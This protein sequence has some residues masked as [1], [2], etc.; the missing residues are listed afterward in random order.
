MKTIFLAG[1]ALTVVML[2]PPADA[3]VRYR[4][5]PPEY[6]GRAYPTAP[7]YRNSTDPDPFIR[8]QILRDIPERYH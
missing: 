6:S 7:F 2:S 3:Q 5:L 4:Q 1:V 8:G